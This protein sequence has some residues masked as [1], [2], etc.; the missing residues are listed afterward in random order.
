MP[1]YDYWRDPDGAY[2]VMRLLRGGN[3]LTA[4]AKGPWPLDRI[5]KLLD[6]IA[7]ALAAAHNQGI[8]HRDIKPA[9][10]LF[11]E[12]GNAYLSDFGIAKDVWHDHQFTMGDGILS[13]PDYASPEQLQ[14]APVSP[15]SDIY[16]MGAVLYEMLTGE[17]PF[18]DAPL[19]TIVQ[20]HLSAPFPLVHESRPDLPAEI[21]EVIQQ[22]IAKRP[23][24]RFPDVLTLAEAFR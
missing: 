18:P 21:D 2:L 11:D 19:V 24:D 22:A 23:S 4:L 1:L 6:Q 3:L 10:I 14:E 16:S 5:Q 17:K 15:Q 12:S 9:N 13:M 20:N 8:V 7:L